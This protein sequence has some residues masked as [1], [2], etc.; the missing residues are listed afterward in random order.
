MLSEGRITLPDG[1]AR[2]VEGARI[3]ALFGLVVLL[4][5]FVARAA[6]LIIAPA[7]AVSTLTPRSLP[8]PLQQVTRTDVRSDLTL[9]MTRNPF[10]GGA[11][12]TEVVT[13]APET[14]LN[15]KLVA[16]FMSTD[17]DADSAT[18]VTP[19]NRSQRF[20]PGEEII[21]GVV[22]ERVMADRVII[23][24]DGSEESLIRGGRQAGLSV[25]GSPS[26]EPAVTKAVSMQAPAQ[27]AP[28]VS[29]RTLLASVEPFAEVEG[30]VVT[31]YTLRPRG[32]P[33]LMQDAGLEPG[34]KLIAVN[35][36]QVSALDTAGLAAEF[37]SARTVSVTVLRGGETQSLDISF[38]EG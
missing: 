26:D 2:L 16:L 36:R 9:L 28:G 21:P 14:S 18:I 20:Q 13:S 19:D 34:D 17:A 12:T 25:L 37:G 15:L 4:A 32:N 30:N 27:F 1:T 3:F 22:L 10:Q 11:T 7:D 31:A 38:E 6:W 5:I 35:G 29:A 8:T 23:S 33:Q 24:R